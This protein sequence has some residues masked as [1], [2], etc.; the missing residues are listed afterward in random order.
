MSSKDQAHTQKK[1]IQE[2]DKGTDTVYIYSV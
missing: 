1:K 2:S